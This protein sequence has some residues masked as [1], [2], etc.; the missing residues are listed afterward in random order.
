MDRGD[1]I[2]TASGPI[3]RCTISLVHGKIR[4]SAIVCGVLACAI[5]NATVYEASMAD[6]FFFLIIHC[7]QDDVF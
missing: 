6:K 5:L 1:N 2:F 4:F 7:Y 3:M